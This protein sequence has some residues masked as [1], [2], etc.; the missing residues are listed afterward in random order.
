[1]YHQ[2]MLNLA[3]PK[4]YSILIPHTHTTASDGM[5]SP[6]S[7]VD[8]AANYAEKL[9]V[10]IFLA[11]TDHDTIQGV[12]KAQNQ[13]RKYPKSIIIICGEEITAGIPIYQK[14]IVALNI[15]KSIKHSMSIYE[16]VAEIK[17]QKGIVIIPHPHV[18]GIPIA[19]LTFG[20]IK[21]ILHMV[22]GIETTNS[23]LFEELGAKVNKIG[24]P[25]S[26]FGSSDLLASFSIFKGNTMEDLKIAFREKSIKPM[27]GT[28]QFPGY[29]EWLKQKIKALGILGARRYLLRNLR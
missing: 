11:I 8:T 7:L 2:K 14:H 12:E 1:M 6:Q 22:D 24:S 26:H 23:S 28:K 10:K 27:R 29:S 13:A 19:S 21:S 18:F 15:K 25:D 9:K 17:K 4:G 3:I 5:V 16:T 20:E